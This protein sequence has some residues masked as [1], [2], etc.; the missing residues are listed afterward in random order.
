MS[1]VTGIACTHVG[2]SPLLVP[3]ILLSLVSLRDAAA[4]RHLLIP[5]AVGLV[6]IFGCWWFFT[7][8]IERFWY[9][10]FPLL[11]L[12]AISGLAKTCERWQH[13]ALGSV[14]GL[15]ILYHGLFLISP[16][17]GDTR[18][19]TRLDSLR[20]GNSLHPNDV[21]RLAT[22][23]RYLNAHASVDHAVL[24]IGEAAVFDSN[25]RAFYNTCFD[26]SL[27]ADWFVDRTPAEQKAELTRRGINW[28]YVNSRELARYRSP[29]NYGYDPRFREEFIAELVA[30]GILHE[31]T[32]ANESDG[33]IRL[34][35]VRVEK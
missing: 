8:R 2:Q 27:A 34:F 10:A 22:T 19:F 23:F 16:L 12:L 11:T 9:P 20:V 35:R 31:V 4:A 21:P 5:T 17:A 24:F 15:G 14:L 32:E 33:T 18:W 25:P 3:L 13:Y 26:D 29:G 1:A 30:A 28:V 7:H 6:W